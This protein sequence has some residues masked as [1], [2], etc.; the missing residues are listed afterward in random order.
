V[1][2]V[3]IAHA[4][5]AGF[6]V[7]TDAGLVLDG[8]LA[9]DT[10]LSTTATVG[11][12]F[13]AGHHGSLTASNARL[14]NNATTSVNVASSDLVLSTT[15]IA[16]TLQAEAGSFGYGCAIFGKSTASLTEV[17]FADNPGVAFVADDS[18]ASISGGLFER[19]RIALHAQNGSA[20]RESD[21]ATPPASGEV[22]VSRSTN[23]V[24]NQVKVGD[25]YVPLPSSL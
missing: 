10:R 19:N 6:D 23:F 16:N 14:L 15:F 7:S 17:T 9:N 18:R 20:V 24:D 5:L 12:G 25:D 13:Q 22:R 11:S 2:N 8:V 3:S 4:T 1:K 21:E